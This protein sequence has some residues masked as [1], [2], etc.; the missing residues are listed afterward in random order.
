M[1]FI[2]KNIGFALYL[3]LN[4]QKIKS[5][6]YIGKNGTGKSK[7]L[8]DIC[9][10]NIDYSFSMNFFTKQ[11]APDDLG[12]NLSKGDFFLQF[13]KFCLKLSEHWTDLEPKQVEKI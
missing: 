13:K 3:K 4:M 12:K 5:E 10:E 1:F 7:K 6:V 11:N 2:Y 9:A 8:D